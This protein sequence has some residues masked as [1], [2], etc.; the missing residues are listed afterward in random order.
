MPHASSVSLIINLIETE[1]FEPIIYQLNGQ[2]WPDTSCLLSFCS[3]ML[4]STD[5]TSWTTVSFE[6]IIQHINGLNLS[7]TFDKEVIKLT[8]R[9]PIRCMHNINHGSPVAIFCSICLFPC[10][11]RFQY[12]YF[13]FIPQCYTV[14][15]SGIWMM[16]L[17]PPGMSSAPHRTECSQFY[18]IMPNGI[19]YQL[20]HDLLPDLILWA[21]LYSRPAI[22]MWCLPCTIPRVFSHRPLAPPTPPTGRYHASLQPERTR[23]SQCNTSHIRTPASTIHHFRLQFTPSLFQTS[24]GIYHDR[25]L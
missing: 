3:L 19:D 21:L 1:F 18:M 4:S 2:N 13:Y 15:L 11:L 20:P 10:C 8:S 25:Q 14:V 16:M 6:L 7:V 22:Q 17:L 5:S 9:I 12:N 23:R 24:P